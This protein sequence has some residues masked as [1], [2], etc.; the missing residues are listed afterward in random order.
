[1]TQIANAGTN[2]MQEYLKPRGFIDRGRT[3]IDEDGDEIRSMWSSMKSDA[4][5][6]ES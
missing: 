2:L 1:M 6:I 5:D 4:D 3:Y